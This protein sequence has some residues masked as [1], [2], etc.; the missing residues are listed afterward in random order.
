MLSPGCN[1]NQCLCGAPGLACSSWCCWFSPGWFPQAPNL[2]SPLHSHQ[3]PHPRGPLPRR[4]RTRHASHGAGRPAL[5]LGRSTVS[6]WPLHEVAPT[7]RRK[8]CGSCSG[9]S[10][11]KLFFWHA[12][13]TTSQWAAP[14]ATVKADGYVRM[15]APSLCRAC[16]NSGNLRS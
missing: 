6:L 11:Y 5:L 3:A 9:L 10:P 12:V 16:D 13:D 2:A 1:R 4:G 14:V 15:W 8:S 7:E